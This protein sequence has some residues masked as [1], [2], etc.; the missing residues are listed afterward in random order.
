MKKEYSGKEVQEISFHDS[1]IDEIK[2]L[3]NGQDITFSITWLPPADWCPG[4]KDSKITSLLKFVWVS[5]LKIDIDFEDFVGSP[6]IYNIDIEDISHARWKVLIEFL[7]APKGE[8]GFE[9]NQ[10]SL[11][12]GDA[13]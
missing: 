11:I 4:T 6:S 9:C 5:D 13:L 7:G 3:N 10:V 1:L 12:V 8:I 2:W